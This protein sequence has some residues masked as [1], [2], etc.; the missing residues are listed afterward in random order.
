MT[1]RELRNI[2]TTENSCRDTLPFLNQPN[3]KKWV[4]RLVYVIKHLPH[5]AFYCDTITG[6]VASQGQRGTF[7]PWGKTDPAG[8]QPSIS[9]SRRRTVTRWI[10]F[11]WILNALSF[12]MFI[13]ARARFIDCLL[14][15]KGMF[16][17]T[18][19]LDI[20]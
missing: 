18:V 12:C 8:H 7:S 4:A 19:S 5:K 15:N 2:H 13:I 10:A 6:K 11:L 3:R 9:L 16:S 17:F 1:P 14:T 20:Q